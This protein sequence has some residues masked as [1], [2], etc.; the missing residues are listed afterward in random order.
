MPDPSPA[1]IYRAFKYGARLHKADVDRLL[2]SRGIEV[3]RNRLYEFGRNSDRGGMMTMEELY[4][5][6]SAWADEQ[7]EDE[8]S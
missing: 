5:I 7:R 1:T 2:R 8:R 4:H 6:I 3:S